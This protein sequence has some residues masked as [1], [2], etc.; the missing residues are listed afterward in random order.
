MN[1]TTLTPELFESWALNPAGP[2]ALHLEQYLV[3]VEGPGAVFFPPTYAD[4]G[5]NIDTLRDGTKVA[6]VDSVGAQANRIE[7]L[8]L[9]QPYRHLVPQI[10]IAYGDAKKGTDGSVSLLEAGHRLGDAVV[11]STELQEEAQMAFKIF[12]RTGD[13]TALAKLAP[14]SLIFGVWDSRDT[15][16]KVPRLLQSVIRAW[17]VSPLTRSAQYVPALDYATLD[18]FSETEKQKAEGKSS[19]ALAQR[20]FVHVPASGEHGGIVAHGDIRRDLTINLVALRRLQ[21]E[22][23]DK[24]RRYLLGLALVSAAAP[25]DPFLRQGCLL[26]PDQDKPAVWCTVA[27]DGTRNPVKLNEGVALEYANAAAKSFGVGSSRALRFDKARAKKDT[28]A[29]DK[30]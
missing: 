13:A 23:S 22:A 16:A 24:L 12:Q 11:R 27:R 1:A 5:Y 4:V 26:V 28:K 2:V 30:K 3:P 17:D 19:S 18:V 29:K 9:E 6:L 10:S 20:G 21:G 7:P 25:Q 14:T 15:Q 8:F